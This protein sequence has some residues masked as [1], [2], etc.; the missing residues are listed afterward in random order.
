MASGRQHHYAVTVEWTGNKG[1][2]TSHYKAYERSHAIKAGE[3]PVIAG[4]ADPAF[5]GDAAAWNPEDLLVASLSAC[6]KLWYLHL[7]AMAG[8]TVQS[9]V[10]QAEGVMAEDANGS[11]RFTSVVLRPQVTIAAGGDLDKAK[12]LHHD[13][14]GFCFIANSVNFPVSVEPV[15]T[16]V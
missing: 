7:C 9:Y 8:I 2:G 6:H 4:S 1:T 3:K 13:A 12:A 14:H 5:R 10:D 16:L 11:G 15:I